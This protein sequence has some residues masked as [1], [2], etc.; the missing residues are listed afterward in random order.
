M[1]LINIAG[2]AVFSN[3]QAAFNQIGSAVGLSEL[4]V[5]PTIIS[6]NPEAGRSN[7]SLELAAE[8]GIDISP[9]ISVSSIKILTANDPFQ[10]G[11]NYRINDEIRLRA[12][13]NLDDDSRAVVEFQRRF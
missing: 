1:G 8:A 7:S 3:F 2:S 9:K 6:N 10:W 11:V 12:S 4:R 5:F 13:T